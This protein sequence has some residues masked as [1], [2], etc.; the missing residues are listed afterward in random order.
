MTILK[1]AC[2]TF[3]PNDPEFIRV[4]HRVYEHINEQKEFD[5]LYSTRFYGPMVFYLV[6][7]KKLNNL[8]SRYLNMAKM[9]EC[10][11]LVR[12][13]AIVHEDV[14]KSNQYL[15][16]TLSDVELLKVSWH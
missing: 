6:W 3:E 16:S 13:Y 7:Y 9:N 8:L 11:D 1:K 2:L 15:N 14:T 12:L 5:V 4:T 10:V